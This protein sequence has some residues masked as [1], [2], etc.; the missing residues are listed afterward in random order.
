MLYAVQQRTARG[1]RIDPEHTK[2]VIQIIEANDSLATMTKAD[3]DRI[4]RRHNTAVGVHLHQFA[5]ALRNGYD[6]SSRT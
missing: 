6:T 4:A 1:G 3:V 5:R 2:A